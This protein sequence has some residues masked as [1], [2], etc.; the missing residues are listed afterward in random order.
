MKKYL[1]WL[2]KRVLANTLKKSYNL[3]K[4]KVKN[5]WYSIKKYSN[6]FLIELN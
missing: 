1:R 5:K 4:K 3:S 2:Y 6:I